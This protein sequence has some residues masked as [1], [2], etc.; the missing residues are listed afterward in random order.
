[1]TSVE[2][3][4]NQM[5]GLLDRLY[6]GSWETCEE[7][8]GYYRQLV[9]N[10]TYHSIPDEWHGIYNEYTFAVENTAA[11]NGGV[12]SLC[13]HGGGGLNPHAYGDARSSIAN[14]LDRL[15]PAIQAANALLGG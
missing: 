7:Y 11:F 12:Y 4:L 3:I 5:G 10:P 9:G 14:G 15:I 13:E 6:N 1:M 8:E 2:W